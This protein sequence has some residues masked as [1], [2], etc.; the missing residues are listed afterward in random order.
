VGRAHAEHHRDGSLYFSILDLAKWD[1]ALYTEK[2]LK[3]SSL[4]GMWTIAKAK[5]WPGEFRH[6]GFGWFIE[7]IRGHR[8]IEHGGAWQ[9]FTT[10]ISRYVDDKLTIVVLTN[11]AGSKRRDITH[12]V[13]GLIEPELA[14]LPEKK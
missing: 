9:G 1:A 13:A 7:N 8:I 11:L 10:N 6:Y 14:P 4:D 2:V 12:H 5:K 3:K